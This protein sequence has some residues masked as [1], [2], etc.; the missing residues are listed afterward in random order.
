M[1]RIVLVR[2]GEAQSALDG[3]VGGEN[4]CTGLSDLGRRQAAALRDRLARTGELRTVDA[5]Y[6]SHLARAVETAE[7]IAPAL[8]DPPV[9]IERELREFDPGS[10]ADGMTWEEYDR[11]FPRD[12]WDAYRG[13][14]P[15]AESWAAF[16]LR[17]GTALRDLAERHPGETVVVACHG[18]VVEQSVVSLLGLAHHGELVTFEVANTSITEWLRPDPDELWWRPPG[19]WRLI[20]LNDAAH[21]D[22][23][24]RGPG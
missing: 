5:L 11:R 21:L 20:R 18:G 8:G 10:Q 7:I 3:V 4:G 16:S 22:G 14:S 1:T 13:R 17:I 23:V 6:A 9:R 19:R 12:P 2:H 24:R 15:G